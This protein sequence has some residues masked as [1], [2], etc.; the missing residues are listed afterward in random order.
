[1]NNL[2][3]SENWF[4]KTYKKLKQQ[5]FVGKALI[6]VDFKKYEEILL[7]V[8]P[9][10]VQELL[11]VCEEALQSAKALTEGAKVQLVVAANN[12]HVSL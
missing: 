9:D 7:S 1:M 8:E 11:G 6:E 5:V 10:Q 3:V 12:L 4:T 2:E